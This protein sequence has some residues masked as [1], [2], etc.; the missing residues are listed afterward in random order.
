M[1]NSICK[2]AAEQKCNAIQ[3]VVVRCGLFA[4]QRMRLFYW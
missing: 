2:V 4:L 1:L 3:E